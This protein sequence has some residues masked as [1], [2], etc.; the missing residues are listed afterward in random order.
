MENE[1]RTDDN[2]RNKRK[3]NYRYVRRSHHKWIMQPVIR[4]GGLYL[5]SFG[6]NAGDEIEISFK[7]G[8]IIIRKITA[9][10][11]LIVIRKAA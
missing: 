4:M 11:N 7:Q 6:F 10:Q 5:K 8:L 1:K 9:K 2:V 3:V